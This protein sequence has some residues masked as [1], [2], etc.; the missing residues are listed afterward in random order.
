VRVN[1]TL[2]CTLRASLLFLLAGAAR[3]VPAQT[4]Q[5][6]QQQPASGQPAAPPD[7]PSPISPLTPLK[8]HTIQEPYT[9]I[10][11]RQ[12]FHWFLTDTIGPVH[13]LGGGIISAGFG[14]LT[15][16]PKEY[17]SSWGGFGDRFGM[18]LTGVSTG[19]AIEATLGA[20]WGEDPRYFREPEKSFGGRVGSVVKQKFEARH[21][22]GAFEPAYA[23]YVAVT[24][25]N[26]LSNT[27]RVHSEAGNSDALLRSGEGFAGRMASNAW[28]EFW[29]SVTSKVFHRGN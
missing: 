19:N 29:P 13:L 27:W 15:D 11:T 7:K 2:R 14:T 24:G 6:D 17:G 9:P 20:A 26:F 4:S 18:R 22:S 1:L 28:E 12:R 5:P 10:T 16:H 8:P 25:N 3:P 23:R 21:P